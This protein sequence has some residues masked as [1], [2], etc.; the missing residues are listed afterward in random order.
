[1]CKKETERS[2]ETGL[3]KKKMFSGKFVIKMK[4]SMYPT[5]FFSSSIKWYATS[6]S[7]LYYNCLVSISTSVLCRILNTN[8]MAQINKN[9]YLMYNIT[10]IDNDCIS[11]SM[12][13]RAPFKTG[14]H[15]VVY[16]WNS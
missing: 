2:N 7:R 11:K 10:F 16:I 4:L 12:S 9:A 8:D 1:M 5:F 6:M 15:I 13:A 14:T 3:Q